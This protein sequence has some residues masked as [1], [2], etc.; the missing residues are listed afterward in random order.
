LV[1]ELSKLTDQNLKGSSTVHRLDSVAELR[2]LLKGHAYTSVIFY[3]HTIDRLAGGFVQG[4]QNLSLFGRHAEARPQEWADALKQ[5][6]VRQ[7]I[8]AGCRS[9]AFAAG[10]FNTAPLIR[11]GGLSFE[12]MDLIIGN[13]MH[14]DAFDIRKQPIRWWSAPEWKP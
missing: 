12:R 5:A 2:R 13:K 14:I 6:G 9:V 4:S 10:V 7:T 8:I 3:G 1:R 11:V